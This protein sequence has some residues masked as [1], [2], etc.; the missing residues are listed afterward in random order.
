[1]RPGRLCRRTFVWKRFARTKRPIGRLGDSKMNSPARGPRTPLQTEYRSQLVADRVRFLLDVRLGSCSVRSATSSK[2]GFYYYHGTFWI[3][4]FKAI[5][6][7][8]ISICSFRGPDPLPR[9]KCRICKSPFGLCLSFCCWSGHL[10]FK[11][12]RLSPITSFVSWFLYIIT[13]KNPQWENRHKI[14]CV[15]S[16]FVQCGMISTRVIFVRLLFYFVS[17]S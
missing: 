3:Y 6:I 8:N 16:Q 17:R 4:V 1:M 15:Y 9:T 11:L 13:A 10:R 2:S 12:T 14:A 7:I 5:N